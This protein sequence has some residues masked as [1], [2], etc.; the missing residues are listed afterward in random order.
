M[1][2]NW[3][4]ALVSCYNEGLCNCGICALF[5]VHAKNANEYQHINHTNSLEPY[6]D[7]IHVVYL[8]NL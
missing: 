3:K 6:T 7:I 4:N 1:N 5:V 8:L 2:G